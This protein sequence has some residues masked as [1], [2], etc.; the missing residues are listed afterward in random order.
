MTIKIAARM[1]RFQMSPSA[2]TSQRARELRQS[3]HDIIALSSGEPDFPTPDHVI[4]A[5]YAAA[6]AGDT[7]YTTTSGTSELKAAIADKFR[8]DNGLEYSAEEIIVAS[9]A[10]QILFNVIMATV[11]QGVEVI[12]AAPYWVA[13]SQMTQMAGGSTIVVPT[14]E[15]SGFKLQ[16]EDLEKAI[17]P[18]TGWLMI[19]SPG[20]PSGAVYTADQLRALADVLRRHPHVG[21]MS[22]DIYE[23]ILFDGR[24]FATIAQV[25][26]DLKDR[27]VTINGA[28]KAYAMTGWR[29]GYAGGPAALV[30]EMGKMQSQATA[31]ACSVS[32][33]AVVAAL[34]GP[35]DFIP[36]RAKA[37]E[38]RR[39]LVVSML[40]QA[41]GL[42]CA[43]PEGAFY[44]FPSCAGLIGR[45]T[46]GG[47]VIEND[48]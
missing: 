14:T 29:V 43:R 18:N 1:S 10:K 41:T 27:C 22:D 31:G 2:A 35:Q 46:P 15:A 33:A 36:E 8:R 16:P 5:A 17:T 48:E 42:T 11:E 30:K 45:R 9:G 20:N 13:Y 21:I 23:H 28:S 44:L 26:P 6:K 19:N 38:H 7:K 37:F 4:D 39:D 3:G 25:A 12:V 40:N 34:T 47:K 32:Q 24:K